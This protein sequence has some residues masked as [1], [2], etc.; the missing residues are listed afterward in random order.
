MRDN[1]HV[2]ISHKS[3]YVI[4]IVTLEEQISCDIRSELADEEYPEQ[5][6]VIVSK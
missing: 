3:G 1:T 5:D 2:G 6:K 4:K